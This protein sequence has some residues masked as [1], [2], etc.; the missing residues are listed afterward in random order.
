MMACRL[1]SPRAAQLIV[2]HPKEN[3]TANDLDWVLLCRNHDWSLSFTA[4]PGLTYETN[5]HYLAN[6]TCLIRTNSPAPHGS[7]LL[8]QHIAPL[9]G[10]GETPGR[11]DGHVKRLTPTLFPGRGWQQDP[12]LPG[13]PSRQ[14]PTRLFANDLHQSLIRHLLVRYPEKRKEA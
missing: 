10:T 2:Q 5:P 7:T 12:Q 3:T 13:Q 11:A 4:T 8:A 1:I 9:E 6:L 14:S